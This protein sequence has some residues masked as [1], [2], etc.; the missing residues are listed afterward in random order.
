MYMYVYSVPVQYPGIQV[1][2]TV[3][4][5]VPRTSTCT[6]STLPY[7]L[8]VQ[9]FGNPLETGNINIFSCYIHLYTQ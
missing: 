3:Y 9:Y 7:T 6:L 5:G 8:R 1:R 2:G 4:R